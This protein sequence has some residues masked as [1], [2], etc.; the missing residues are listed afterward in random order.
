MAGFQ[1]HISKCSMNLNPWYTLCIAIIST[2]T[3]IVFCIKKYI[4]LLKHRTIIKDALKVPV[5]RAEKRKLVEDQ[6][7]LSLGASGMQSN[8]LA[9]INKKYHKLNKNS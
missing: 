8:S 6:L 1:T 3:T 2:S 5:A 7:N 4:S 9:L